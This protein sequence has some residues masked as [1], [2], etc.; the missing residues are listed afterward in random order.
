MRMRIRK[1]RKYGH[2]HISHGW[3]IEHPREWL[4]SLANYNPIP[5]DLAEI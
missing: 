4:A 3:S 5:Q 2:H 1:A